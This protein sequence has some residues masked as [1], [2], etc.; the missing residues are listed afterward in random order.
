[1]RAA[2]A[3]V[4]ALAG[5]LALALPSG[6]GGPP[7][8]VAI[9]FSSYRP[10]LQDVLPG[11]TVQWSNGSTRT[12]TVT[13]DTGLFDSGDVVSGSRFSFTFNE[14]G[15]Y[16]YH[17]TIHPSITG[18]ID[19][20]RVT[21]GAVPS[22]PLAVGTKVELDG[23]TADPAQAVTIERRVEGAA[24]QA[25]A[26]V[27]PAA[28]GTWKTSVTADATADYRASV[29]ADASELRRVVVQTRKIT[30]RAAAG[31]ITVTVAPSAPYSK[32]L[33]EVFLRER[34]GW[35]PVASGKVN[36]VSEA[37]VKLKGPARVR[38]VLVDRDGWT[39][40]ATSKV[41]VLKKR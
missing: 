24:F 28:D 26:T 11:E 19:V 5:S 20:R 41:V 12:H 17:C 18:E 35:W 40:L 9:E 30:V 7:V 36:Y 37:D 21:L 22:A 4:A 16:K 33:V 2:F 34:F 32:F 13:S 31:G 29:G 8:P 1:M 39:P 38:A 14:V 3:V 10:D 15:A 27:Q 6:A 23:R 25:V